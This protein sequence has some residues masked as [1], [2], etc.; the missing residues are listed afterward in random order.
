VPIKLRLTVPGKLTLPTRSL[1]AVAGMLT[2]RELRTVPAVMLLTVPGVLTVN[3]KLRDQPTETTALAVPT[4]TV[5]TVT[6]LTKLRRL[7][8]PRMLTNTDLRNVV[9]KLTVTTSRKSGMLL[10][11]DLRAV[12]NKVAVV[13]VAT[14]A[15][16]IVTVPGPNRRTDARLTVT[17]AA[18]SG[19][20]GTGAAM[21]VSVVTVPTMTMTVTVGP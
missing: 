21:T 8:V 14:V 18:M 2:V 5:L 11:T 17:M 10:T 3:N 16:L 20:E 12:G 7:T 9:N 15:V 6:E 1:R 19:T 4:M 13:T